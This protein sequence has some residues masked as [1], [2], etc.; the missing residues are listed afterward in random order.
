MEEAEGKRALEIARSAIELWVKSKKK[1]KPKNYSNDFDKKSGVFVTIF[2][3]P[4]N[5]LRGCIGY[6]EP[7]KPL[8]D[9]LIDSALNATH[10]PRFDPLLPDEMG[11]II[12][13]VSILSSP[14]LIKVK[15][16]GEYPNNVEIGTDGLIVQLGHNRGLLLPEVAV[17]HDMSAEEFLAQTCIKAGLS[18]DAWMQR[19]TKVYKFQSQIFKEKEPKK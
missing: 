7:V 2:S 19:E 5:K 10:D 16:P 17:E 11:K 6:P 8:I 18:S 13:H 3:Y 4:E 12:I 14:Q 9:A 1:L 15:D